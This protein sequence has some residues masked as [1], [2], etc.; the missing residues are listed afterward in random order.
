MVIVWRAVPVNGQSSRP[1]S[2]ECIE[3]V[4]ADSSSI[5]HDRWNT[6]PWIAC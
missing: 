2:G 3:I 5:D 6:V 1:V 4:V